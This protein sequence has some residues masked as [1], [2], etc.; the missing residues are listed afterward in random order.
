MITRTDNFRGWFRTWFGVAHSE[1][2]GYLQGV[3]RAG[4]WLADPASGLAEFRAELAGHIRDSSY[5]VDARTRGQ[6][7]TDEWL[8]NIY[9]DAFG[10]QP[11]AGDP[12][13][14]PADAWR[15]RLTDYALD[16]VGLDP[17]TASDGAR[18]WL[19]ARGL[20]FEDVAA[21][22]ADPDATNFRA[23]PDGYG[24]RLRELSVAGL[25]ESHPSDPQPVDQG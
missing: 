16:G 24:E 4:E 25:R 19:A 14:V 22:H 18:D 21:A 23:Q 20:T 13:P 8:R 3:E 9:F 7:A 5:P 12:Y 6:W 10:P 15:T 17:D 1:P 2:A 11:P